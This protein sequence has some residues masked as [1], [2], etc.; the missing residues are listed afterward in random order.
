M[1][2]NRLIYATEPLKVQQIDV[3]DTALL[4]VGGGTTGH[5]KRSAECSFVFFS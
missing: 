1:P 5:S 4:K 2:R 3:P